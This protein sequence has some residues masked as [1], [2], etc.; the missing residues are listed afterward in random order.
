MKPWLPA[1]VQQ[2]TGSLGKKRGLASKLK[3]SVPSISNDC[4]KP[5]HIGP[6]AMTAQSPPQY[7]YTSWIAVSAD[8]KISIVA[9]GST[10]SN[11]LWTFLHKLLNPE[12]GD[13]VIHWEVSIRFTVRWEQNYRPGTH[14]PTKLMTSVL[15]CYRVARCA[16]IWHFTIIH[17]I[18]MLLQLTPHWSIKM[19]C[20]LRFVCAVSLE[21]HKLW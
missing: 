1:C 7:M 18:F 14:T 12:V 3:E 9:A 10:W 16:I 13:T 4:S 19:T 11:Q 20:I 6:S 5:N 15:H 8:G 2:C 17:E 21:P